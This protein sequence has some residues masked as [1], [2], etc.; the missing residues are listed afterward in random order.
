[1]PDRDAALADLQRIPGVGPSIADDLYRLGFRAANDLRDKD[2]EAIYRSLM[3][4]EGCHVDRCVLYVFRCAVNFV[5][6]DEQDP[7]R[8]NWWHWKD[9]KN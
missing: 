6:N 4:L 8:L 3:A 2:P 7:D 9:D 5:T 1:M